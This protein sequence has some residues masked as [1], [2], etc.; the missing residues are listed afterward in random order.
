M[1]WAWLI[2]AWAG[3][4]AAGKHEPS[5]AD[6]A[7]YTKALAAGRAAQ[8]KKDWKTAVAR[9][10][11]A[12]LAI[13]DD[14]TAL[15][16][17][18]WTAFLAG[19][20]DIAEQ[21][22]R[23]AIAAGGAPDPTGAAWFNLGLIEEKKGDK[24]AAI[25]AY[26]ASLRLRP[27]GVVRAALARI[28]AK[29]AAA[30]D[31]YQPVAMAPIASIDAWCKTQPQ[32]DDDTSC[33]CTHEALQPGFEHVVQGCAEKHRE[34]G[35]DYHRLALRVGTAWFLTPPVV[36]GS[37]NFHCSWD[38]L[39]TTGT[40]QGKRFVA[41]LKEKGECS[42]GIHEDEWA[43]TTIVA[44][45]TRKGVAMATPP[46]GITRRE[47]EVDEGKRLRDVDLDVKFAWTAKG[48]ALTGKTTG[49]ERG[50]AT[51]LVGEHAVE[52]DP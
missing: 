15:G 27:H 51:D 1:K 26:T 10:S 3:V 16:E 19:N 25:A 39:S 17:L 43:T 24:P 34:V 46:I 37:V 21:M 7:K 40:A 14:A 41:E 23:K 18:G 36:T 9:F 48:F 44:V 4:A 32:S 35:T 2:A 30:A 49:I 22:T 45:G 12:Q 20:L 28:D 11:E 38:F 31:P 13:P 5:D 47:K 42:N 50:A 29:A 52:L 6:R 8:A 33:T